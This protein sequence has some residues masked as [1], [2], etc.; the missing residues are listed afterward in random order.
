MSPQTTHTVIQLSLTQVFIKQLQPLD[1]AEVESE[2]ELIEHVGMLGSN[3]KQI[4]TEPNLWALITL[5]G[6]HNRC[7]LAHWN[8]EQIGT[9][10]VV[11]T[12]VFLKAP[13][14]IPRSQL[15]RALELYR[16]HKSMGG[17]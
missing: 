17:I 1:K 13:G 6:S 12:H 3:F 5:A 15:D 2:I 14:P 4:P 8:P 16:L 7:I 11:C 10:Y 9:S